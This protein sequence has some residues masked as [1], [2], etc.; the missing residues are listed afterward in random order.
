MRQPR[1]SPADPTTQFPS[2]KRNLARIGGPRV[3]RIAHRVVSAVQP[4]LRTA[5]GVIAIA[6]LAACNDDIVGPEEYSSPLPGADVVLTS[7]VNDDFDGAV[8]ITQVPFTD[9]T[10]TSDALTAVDDPYCAG[11][12]PTV[13]YAFT[14]P[15]DGQY[16]ANTFGSDYD[17]TLGAYAG[18]RGSLTEL[19]CNDDASGY[20]SQVVIQLAAGETVYF[21]VGAFSSGPGGNLVFNLNHWT[22]P[23]PPPPLTAEITLATVGTVDPVTGI[24]V[25]RGTS[26]CSLGS[27]VDL[28]GILRQRIGRIIIEASFW[29]FG[30]CDGTSSWEAQVSAPNALL[31]AGPAEVT[32]QAFFFDPVFGQGA[33]AQQSGTVRLRGGSGG[34]TASA[35]L[36]RATLGSASIRS[37]EDVIRNDPRLTKMRK[38]P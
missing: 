32:V 8:V 1:G 19:A 17:T 7:A 23:P 21:M 18:T 13:W 33:F 31:T 26:T 28:F 3:G 2:V 11:Q 27:F 36:G 35:S 10:N 25:V 30:V 14:A 9:S 24:A 22:P 16:E 15:A 37:L 34:A 20:L 12:G 4:R 6:V 38:D 5:F 29:T